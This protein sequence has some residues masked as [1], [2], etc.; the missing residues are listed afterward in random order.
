MVSQRALDLYRKRV[1]LTIQLNERERQIKAAYAKG[2][3]KR[4][5]N[6]E[7]KFARLRNEWEKW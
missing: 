3:K 5:R 2:N 4:A 1:H 6:L 7:G